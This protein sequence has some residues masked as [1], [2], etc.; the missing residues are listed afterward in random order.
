MK[1]IVALPASTVLLSAKNQ[2]NDHVGS[3][4]L[5]SFQVLPQYRPSIVWEVWAA[6]KQNDRISGSKC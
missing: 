5:D 3:A 2:S 6:E 1:E 4:S